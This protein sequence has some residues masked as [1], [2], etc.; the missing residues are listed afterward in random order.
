[1]K[2]LRLQAANIKK[3]RIV[4]ITPSGN[5]VQISGANG[6]GKSSVL[7]SI[8]WA[9]EGTSNISALPVR[10]GEFRAKIRLDLG[11]VIVTRSF[12]AGAGSTL[13]VES[14]DGSRFASPQKLLDEL[15]GKLTFDPLEFSRMPAKQQLD[16]LKGIAKIDVDIEALDRANADDYAARTEVNRTVKSL[17]ERANDLFSKVDPSVHGEPIDTDELISQMETA[18]S[19]N[20]SVERQRSDREMAARSI[21]RM[22]S[23]VSDWRRQIE[24]LQRMIA[25][26][27]RIA[28]HEESQLA[29]LAP[30]PE[31]RDTS[32]IRAEID[33]A[34]R[35]NAALTARSEYETA[36]ASENAARKA[37]DELT[38][39]MADRE[40]QK[41]EAI[42][43]AKMPIEGLGFGDGMVL[44]NGLPF[45]QASSAE[46]L[47]VSVAIAM[48]ANPKLRVLRIKDGSLLDERSLAM[49]AEMAKAEDYQIWI[50][51]VDTSGTVGIVLEDGEV[52]KVNQAV[53]RSGANGAGEKSSVSFPMPGSEADAILGP[54]PTDEEI[55][56]NIKRQEERARRVGL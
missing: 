53:E 39:K 55:N 20:A 15:L 51:T 14:A 3:L 38:E 23:K 35:V 9:L 6:E 22:R 43:Q 25:A 52:V 5:V 8:Q 34:R 4:D 16:E 26:E 27:E 40:R 41:A 12:K 42:A 21:E 11:D 19:F 50:E 56:A 1:M 33:R 18:A 54:A 32:A 48:A 37:A 10:Q 29:A 24:D 46:Q 7:D 36:R 13:N 30:L 45:D 28:E 47:R 2:I 49:I 17:T 44:Y 31:L